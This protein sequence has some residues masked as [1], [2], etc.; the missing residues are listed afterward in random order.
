[1]S[2]RKR[3]TKVQAPEKPPVVVPKAPSKP[4]P[5]KA[6]K[7]FGITAVFLLLVL[8]VVVYLRGLSY[9]LA[10]SRSTIMRVDIS[11]LETSDVEI[12]MNSYNRCFNVPAQNSVGLNTLRDIYWTAE[13]KD[14]SIRR[15]FFMNSE[16]TKYEL[17]P[18]MS[19]DPPDLISQLKPWLRTSVSNSYWT[20][21]RE[22]EGWWHTPMAIAGLIYA[23]AA[24]RK[25]KVKPAGKA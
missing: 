18:A 23:V 6:S 10:Y 21:M 16:T 2:A 3:I 13:W 17:S 20:W 8:L 12:C 7:K 9:A 4:A 14:R 15:D 22:R 5:S 25:A 11:N 24:L 1:M 19:Y